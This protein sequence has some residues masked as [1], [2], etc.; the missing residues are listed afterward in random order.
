VG[1][2]VSSDELHQSLQDSVPSPRVSLLLYVLKDKHPRLGI[3]SALG[4]VVATIFRYSYYVALEVMIG[5]KSYRPARM[6]Q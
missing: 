1:V 4:A 2:D 5:V 3:F 6:G